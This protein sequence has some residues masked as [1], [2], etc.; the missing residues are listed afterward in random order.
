MGVCRGGGGNH[1]A[2]IFCKSRFD[3]G[4]RAKEMHAGPGHGIK[5]TASVLVMWPGTLSPR[6]VLHLDV[7]TKDKLDLT[8]DD[9][10]LLVTP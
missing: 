4:R 7:A 8:F 3:L 5:A 10:S 9:A 2:S 6:T 1:T